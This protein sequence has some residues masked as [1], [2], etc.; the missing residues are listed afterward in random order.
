MASRHQP[1]RFLWA[2]SVID[3]APTDQILEIGCGAGLL[4]EQLAQRIRT[5]T[6]LALDKSAPMIAKATKRNTDHIASGRLKTLTSNFATAS[7][8]KHK[9]DKIVG[10]NVNFFWKPDASEYNLI[11]NYLKPDGRIYVFHQ[12]PTPDDTKTITAIQNTMKV[13]GLNVI[14]TKKLVTTPAPAYGIIACVS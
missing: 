3:A 6:I 7:L 12:A 4:A 5:G 13:M 11:K 1:D 10:F 8:P 14:S 9:F 2:C